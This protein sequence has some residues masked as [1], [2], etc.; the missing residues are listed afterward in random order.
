LKE[1]IKSKE[2][3]CKTIEDLKKKGKKIVFTNGCF[4]LLHLGHIRYLEKSKSLGDILV[5]GVNSDRS[6][7][8]LKG[9]ERP[10]LPEE[11]RTEILSSLACVDYV[12]VFD[13]ITPLELISS[14]QPHILVKGGDWAKKEA[15]VGWEVVERSGGEVVILPFIEGSSTSNLIE[16]IL[17]RFLKK[18]RNLLEHT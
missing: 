15:V 4:D 1:K 14:L 18:S 16:T 17:K 7:R 11:E 6:V 13:E 12:T 8:G 10:I 5:V 3:L 2:V 9:P